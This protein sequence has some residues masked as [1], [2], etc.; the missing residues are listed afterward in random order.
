MTLTF[1]ENNVY[2]CGFSRILGFSTFL[3]V[4]G[5]VL[6]LCGSGGPVGVSKRGNIQAMVL[7]GVSV[8][9]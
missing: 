9:C 8:A 6:R 2:F 4:A 5:G 1:W 7:V 3:F